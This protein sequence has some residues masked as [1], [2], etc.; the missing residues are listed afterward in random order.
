MARLIE[1]TLK[2]P[3]PQAGVG[4]NIQLMRPHQGRE[5]AHM[6]D[7][8]RGIADARKRLGGSFKIGD[9]IVIVDSSVVE[10]ALVA[11]EIA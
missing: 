7:T 3:A 11:L 2:G 6:T 8:T 10:G 9:T 1:G 5:T 4:W